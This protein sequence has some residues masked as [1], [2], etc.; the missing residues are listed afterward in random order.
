MQELPLKRMSDAKVLICFNFVYVFYQLQQIFE[1]MTT[2]S[3]ASLM[4]CQAMLQPVPV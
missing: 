2:F 3:N 4:Y 1:Q